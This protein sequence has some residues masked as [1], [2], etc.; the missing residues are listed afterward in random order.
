MPSCDALSP[1]RAASA[2]HFFLYCPVVGLG[3]V[4]FGG[5]VLTQWVAAT[6][7]STAS[8]CVAGCCTGT[9]G[10]AS[11]SAS[12]DMF[13]VV[14]VGGCDDRGVR[15]RRTYDV[16]IVTH[17]LTHTPRG[18][19]TNTIRHWSGACENGSTEPPWS[20]AK[21]A[22]THEVSFAER[23]RTMPV[24]TSVLKLFAGDPLLNGGPDE[25]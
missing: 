15:V 9:V 22:D 13:F 19:H 16:V 12:C 2:Q 4:A 17:P 8:L 20:S 23:S 6:P 11:A 5:S 24:A 18:H 21:M 25:V 3:V 1:G 14:E 10:A 7:C